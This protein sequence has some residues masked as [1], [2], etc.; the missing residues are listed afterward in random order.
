VSLIIIVAEESGLRG[1]QPGPPATEIW[2]L[3]LPN[4]PFAI[5]P[6]GDNLVVAASQ[7][8][9]VIDNN[10]RIFAERSFGSVGSIATDSDVIYAGVDGRF[11]CLSDGLE[12][13]GSIALGLDEDYFRPE[14]NVDDILIH[15][16]TAFLVD[17]VIMPLY[18]FKADI[19][20]K[21]EP[22]ITDRVCL[23][24]VNA[25]LAH[26]F[27][28]PVLR[29]WIVHEEYGHQGGSGEIL[30]FLPL[31]SPF[32]RESSRIRSHF[33]QPPPNMKTR[34]IFR[35]ELCERTTGH[36]IADILP[37]PP[38]WAVILDGQIVPHLAKLNTTNE[39]PRFSHV[40]PLCTKWPEQ[41]TSS[42]WRTGFSFRIR[43]VAD[44]IFVLP[45]VEHTDFGDVMDSRIS[46]MLVEYEIGDQRPIRVSEFDLTDTGV[47]WAVDFLIVNGD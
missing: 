9:T 47:S 37:F 34:T 36:R 16:N 40:T 7:T 26:Q 14:K 45:V 39:N 43:R 23:G 32:N 11:C 10:H 3:P 2:N 25:H 30:H 19:S 18:I 38:H 12:E 13:I 22:V 27:I 15:Q 33:E 35:W 8:I 24:G 17:D 28:N 29:Q 44:R 20:N 41:D 5:S 1:I 4:P 31:Y 42:H 6:L 46:P 21:N